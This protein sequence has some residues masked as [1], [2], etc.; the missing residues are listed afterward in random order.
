ML[1]KNKIKQITSLQRKKWRQGYF[2]AEGEKMAREAI[3]QCPERI[4]SLFALDSW[5]KNQHGLLHQAAFPIEVIDERD[6]R[7]ISA[8][9]TPNNVVFI[10]QMAPSLPLPPD[11]DRRLSLY[12]DGIQDPGNMGTILRI[13]DWFG[14][15][16]VICS[17][18]CADVYAPKVVQASM[19]AVF[20]VM[21]LRESLVRVVEP[22]PGIP[23]YG[24]L[25]EGDSL[26][27]T[28][29]ERRG[30]IV[31]GNEGSGISPACRQMITQPLTIPKGPGSKADSLNAAVATGIICAHFC[32]PPPDLL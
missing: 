22:F 5:V 25:L 4:H 1:S 7:R 32:S 20:R 30:I 15:D 31:I 6:L 19:G 9:T 21:T 3:L 24:T 27:A 17:P 11:L 12:L 28:T 2:L 16:R 10:M 8:L 23:I 18:T 29:F 26:F 14:L 13:A